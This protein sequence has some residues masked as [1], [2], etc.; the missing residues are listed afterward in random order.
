M[1]VLNRESRGLMPTGR[2]KSTD[3][4]SNDHVLDCFFDFVIPSSFVISASF[5]SSP[6]F[7]SFRALI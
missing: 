5:F 2:M 6:L 7:A 3:G 4:S 1:S